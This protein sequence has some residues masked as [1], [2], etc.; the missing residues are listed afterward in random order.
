LEKQYQVRLD[1]AKLQSYGLSL[2]EVLEVYKGGAVTPR[3]YF[4]KQHLGSLEVN[5]QAFDLSVS[6]TPSP[7]L[8]VEMEALSYAPHTTT[9]SLPVQDSGSVT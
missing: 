5:R 7:R 1:P 2:R 3:L 8:Q 9:G 4:I 6:Y